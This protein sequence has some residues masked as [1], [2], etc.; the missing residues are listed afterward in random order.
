MAGCELLGPL[1]PADSELHLA[2]LMLVG[3]VYL[4]TVDVTWRSKGTDQSGVDIYSQGARMQADA[5]WTRVAKHNCP[6]SLARKNQSIPARYPEGR[7]IRPH[8]EI[9]LQEPNPTILTI[10]ST[11]NDNSRG[12]TD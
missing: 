11:R 5:R 12:D 9:L 3:L 2:D 4:V 10:N 1:G 6:S 8:L 7:Y